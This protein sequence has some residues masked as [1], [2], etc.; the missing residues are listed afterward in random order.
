MKKSIFAIIAAL[1]FMSTANIFAE[2]AKFIRNYD[3]GFRF[4]ENTEYLIW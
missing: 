2:E 3:Y 4:Y 1:T